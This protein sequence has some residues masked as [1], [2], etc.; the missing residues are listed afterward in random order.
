MDFQLRYEDSPEEVRQKEVWAAAG[1]P[2]NDGLPIGYARY[3]MP[4]GSMGT[5]DTSATPDLGQTFVGRLRLSPERASNGKPGWS[6]RRLLARLGPGR[7][8][9]DVETQWERVIEWPDEDVACIGVL[10]GQH[11]RVFDPDGL[12]YLVKKW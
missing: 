2:W 11:T 1:A 5:F 12:V 8:M 10:V 9:V 3:Q 4:D 6:S 7:Y